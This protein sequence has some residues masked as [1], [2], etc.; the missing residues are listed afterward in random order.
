MYFPYNHCIFSFSWKSDFHGRM[1]T[2][3]LFYKI[4]KVSTEKRPNAITMKNW[5]I[6]IKIPLWLL[7]L[8]QPVPRTNTLHKTSPYQPFLSP[9][10]CHLAKSY[11]NIVACKNSQILHTL[12]QQKI[13]YA[14][15]NNG[16]IEMIVK[17]LGQWSPPPQISQLPAQLTLF[18]FFCLPY[19][20]IRFQSRMAWIH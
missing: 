12:S 5:L 9:L 17:I 14:L 13:H 20:F 16:K 15:I 11:A 6:K 18:Q 8:P 2:L 10:I 19:F 4:Q 3:I 7:I 1:K